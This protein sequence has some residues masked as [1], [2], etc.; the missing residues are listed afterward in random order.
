[1]RAAVITEG[2][3]FDLATMPDPSPGPGELVVRVTA[4]GVCGSDIKARP[5]MPPGT[6]M[7]GSPGGFAE[8][9]DLVSTAAAAGRMLVVP[10][11]A[12]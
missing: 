11:E 3:G 9:F 2:G 7:G 5:F 1:M 12:G 8:A 10:E 4:C 6:V